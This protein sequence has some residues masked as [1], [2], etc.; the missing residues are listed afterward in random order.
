MP[1]QHQ[2]HE[3]GHGQTPTA[4]RRDHKP[5]RLNR[6]PFCLAVRHPPDGSFVGMSTRLSEFGGPLNRADC[7]HSL[8]AFEPLSF[9][10]SSPLRAT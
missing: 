5:L 7:G 10:Q 9:T 8:D 3:T 1:L 6:E 4:S 2:E